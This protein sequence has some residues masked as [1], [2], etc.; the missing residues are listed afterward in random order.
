[1]HFAFH[2]TRSA[3][4]SAA[5]LFEV[6][7]DY[8]AYPRFD[9]AVTDVRLV[10]KDD[11]G[12]EFVARRR[13]RTSRWVRAYDRYRLHRDLV[14]ERTFAGHPTACCTWTIHPVD[15]WRSVLTVEESRHLT[16]LR[17]SLGRARVTPFIHEA[18]RRAKETRTP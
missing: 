14:V 6:L 3:Q 16:S 2:D 10:S 1:M 8:A 7:T 4:A 11:V 9:T 18:E 5:V 12:A 13:F 17:R 15:L